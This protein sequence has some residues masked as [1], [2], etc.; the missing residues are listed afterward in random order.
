MITTLLSLMTLSNC[1]DA[2]NQ[3]IK[4]DLVQMGADIE[5]HNERCMLIE[6][7]I[8]PVPLQQRWVGI[9]SV[10]VWSCYGQNY[11]MLHSCSECG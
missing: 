10:V 8:V 2:M 9:P 11:W 5:K 1:H 3:L 6:M 7:T 4:Q